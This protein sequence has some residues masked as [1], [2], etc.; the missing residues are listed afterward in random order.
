MKKTFLFAL[1][2]ILVLNHTFSKPKYKKKEIEKINSICEKCLSNGI[3]YLEY[4]TEIDLDKYKENDL[5]KLDFKQIQFKDYKE[6]SEIFYYYKD[7]YSEINPSLGFDFLK[8]ISSDYYVDNS[9]FL[10]D[11]TLIFTN[12]TITQEI[13]VPL[14]FFASFSATKKDDI[15]LRLMNR[16][17]FGVINKEQLEKNVITKGTYFAEYLNEEII[18][19]Q[20]KKNTKKEAEKNKKEKEIWF[21][22]ANVDDLYNYLKTTPILRNVMGKK[23]PSNEIDYI[24]R[25]KIKYAL[26]LLKIKNCKIQDL[27]FLILYNPHNYEYSDLYYSKE[28]EVFQ[29]VNEGI[30]AQ[31][32]NTDLTVLI[33]PQ[34]IRKIKNT[35][36]V[37][38]L[39]YDGVFEYLNTE[40]KLVTIPK[41]ILLN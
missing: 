25:A 24:E 10:Y 12:A 39:K 18:N 30:L 6:G 32:K 20:N 27:D 28:I 38:F 13:H 2:S 33:E 3:Y 22:N 7:R 17:I 15:E 36:Y 5:L 29:Y 1:I 26:N 31:I 9:Y 19:I 41:F 21:N 4:D 8:K 40:N 35:M 34:D 16:D 23:Y 14:L 37:N 11:A